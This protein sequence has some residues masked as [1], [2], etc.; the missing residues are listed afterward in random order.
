M[1]TIMQIVWLTGALRRIV[2]SDHVVITE[3]SHLGMGSSYKG[4]LD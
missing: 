3:V 4:H 1:L 2:L